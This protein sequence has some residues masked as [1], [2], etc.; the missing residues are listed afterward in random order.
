VASFPRPSGLLLRGR[1]LGDRLRESLLFIPSGMMVVAALIERSLAQLDRRHAADQLP[2]LLRLSPEAAI[3]LLSTI[4]GATITT[5]GVVF[6]LIVVTL[7][8]ASGQFSPRVLRSY[9]RDWMGQL[10]VG[11]LAAL[12]AYS[13]LCLRAVRPATAGQP[14]DVPDLAVNFAVLLTLL[15]V[16]VLVVF[17]HRLARRQYVGN[18]MAEITQETLARLRDATA[19]RS[20]A[21]REAPPDV[22][23][24]GPPFVVRSHGDGWVQQVS[25]DGLLSAV[26]HASVARL[27]T[28]VGAYT[29]RGCPLLSI[30]PPPESPGAVERAVRGEVIIGPARTMQQDLDFGLRQVADIGLRAL[31]SAINDPTTAIEALLN[32]A[33]VLR[34]LLL[35]DLPGRVRRDAHGSVLW[36]PWDLDH[37][38]YVRH[39]LIQFRHY[40]AS[41]PFVA[42]SLVR[43]LRML[44]EAAERANRP[45]AIA[46]LQRQLSLTLEQCDRAGLLP[47]ELGAVHA[48]ATTPQEFVLPAAPPEQKAVH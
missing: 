34:P 48:A 20:T 43:T 7:Q 47:D 8:L 21:T 1:A 35:T 4:A 27:D 6:S 2:F 26:P 9:F 39:A 17:L 15:S 14:L 24:L 45:E 40:G 46:E 29:V 25:S 22:D 23:R 5:V 41:D 30:W 32:I 18:L 11:L 37:A 38:E 44:L 42:I 16:I 19:A 10:L 31:S 33:S 3:A 28:R 36:R 12:F 13:V